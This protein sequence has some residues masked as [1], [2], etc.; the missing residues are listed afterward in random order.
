MLW[1]DKVL[2]NYWAHAASLVL[3]EDY[4]IHRRQ[5]ITWGTGDSLWAGRVREWMSANQ[6]LRRHILLQLRRRGPLRSRD[7]EDRSAVHWGSSGWTDRRNVGRMLDFLWAQGKVMV[8]GRAGAERL[9]ALGSTWWPEWMPRD[10][11]S[12]RQAVM[13]AAP[14]S[15]RCLGVATRRHIFEHFIRGDYPGL[16]KALAALEKGGEIVRAQ[17]QGLNRGEWFVH[18]ADLS[19]IESI[20][21]DGWEPRT[22]L[23]S[24]FDNLICDR[25]RTEVLFDFHYRIEIYVPKDKRRFGYFSMPV[26][27]GD[28]LIGRVDPSFDRKRAA[29]VVNSA[30]AEPSTGRSRRAAGAVREAIEELAAWLGARSIEYRNVTFEPW[31]STL[32]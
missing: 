11:L 29:L 32:R 21:S 25:A 24:P 23:L 18:S 6:G 2:F 26:L 7:F 28:R 31:R 15:L 4:P 30:H 12:A 22:V 13:R 14:I 19:L 5:M 8:A 9:W 1:N 3:T 20:E 27:H 16:D 17:V 10:R